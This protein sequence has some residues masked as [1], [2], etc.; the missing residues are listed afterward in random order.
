MQKRK[1]NIQIQETCKEFSNPIAWIKFREKILENWEIKH[2]TWPALVSEL[3]KT[4]SDILIR[5]A[6][7][8]HRGRTIVTKE[9]IFKMFTLSY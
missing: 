7:S 9:G 6:E 1:V 3:F 2:Y 4:K 5:G 8:I